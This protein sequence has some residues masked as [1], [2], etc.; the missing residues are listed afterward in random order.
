MVEESQ[1]G[2]P[3]LA[4]L[5]VA[6]LRILTMH[7]SIVESIAHRLHLKKLC[8]QCKVCKVDSTRKNIYYAAQNK[9]ICCGI[10][11]CDPPYS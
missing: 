3:M 8:S 4:K 10:S 7:D 1:I 11:L 5:V 6:L 9:L 2:P